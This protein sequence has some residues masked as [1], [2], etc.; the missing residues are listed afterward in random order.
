V[1]K[2]QA[3]GI[4]REATQQS[5]VAEPSY[6]EL[7]FGLVFADV[8]LDGWQDIVLANGHIEPRINDVE[9]SVTY[10][11]PMKLLGN[12]G[13]G[14]FVDWTDS[15]GKPF[16]TPLVGRGLAVGDLDG[17]GDLD[18]VVVEN[19]GN[20]HIIRNDSAPA[21]YL[22]VKL[23][24]RDGNTDAIGAIVSLRAGGV[25]QTRMVRTGSSYLSQSE[26][27]Q[28]FGLGE[29]AAVDAVTV[30]WPDGQLTSVA[31]PPIRRTMVIEEG[32]KGAPTKHERS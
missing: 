18:I 13:R 2:M 9:E 4:F 27:V 31:N 23:R 11:E 14:G 25:T 29:Q 26:L 1:F 16:A 20:L 15:A 10:R 3:P 17:D 24:G 30:R 32:L 6:M 21:N 5:G 19:G 22:R 12:D 28:T 8:D 7:K